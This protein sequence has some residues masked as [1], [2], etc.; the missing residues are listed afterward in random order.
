MEATARKRDS[1]E[2]RL[3]YLSF[4]G[5]SQDIL[6]DLKPMIE[7]ALDTALDRFYGTVRA[8]PQLRAFF[9]SDTQMESAR[10]KQISHWMALGNRGIDADFEARVKR[11]G[12]THARIGL[13]AQWYIASYAL[14]LEELIRSIVKQQQ[15]SA[16]RFLR[17][18]SSRYDLVEQLVTLI[19]TALVDI[20]LSFSS[21]LEAEAEI[22]EKTQVEHRW[23]LDKLA[24][25]LEALAAGDLSVSLNADG[26]EGNERL[27]TALNHAVASISDII[28]EAQSSANGVRSR[29]E[30]IA[31][32]ADD[33]ARRT[34]QQAASLEETAAS[35]TSVSD[36]VRETA[37]SARATDATVTHA[38]NDAKTGGQVAERTQNA[39]RNIENSSRE[40]SQIISVIDEIAFQ[41]NLLALN[42]GVEAARAGEA[43]KGFAVVASEVRTL[44]QRSAE[45]AK[46]I[47]TLISA[48]SDHVSE[49]VSLVEKTSDVLTRTIEAFEQVSQQVNGIA[50]ATEAQATSISEIN[51]A[52][53]Y[54]DEMTQR[55]AA[56]VEETTAAGTALKTDADSLNK[57]VQR[58]VLNAAAS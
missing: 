8:R 23:A 29:A 44:A 38:L 2:E 3:A 36:M 58:F 18:K 34:E 7:S 21:Y 40:M 14:I 33:L 52:V 32:A 41:T 46:S 5:K 50:A 53:S 16:G 11:I 49:G 56:M 12:R 51:S 55:N 4:D 42:A 47:K 6:R 39:M 31:D 10:K 15:S 19:K 28:R 1:L 22:R 20:D 17:N 54:L 35:V 43:G 25:S 37:D 13:D 27:I 57:L 24:D 9:D 48:S 45:A 30:A 26:I